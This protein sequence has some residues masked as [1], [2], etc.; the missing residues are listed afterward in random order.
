MSSKLLEHMAGVYTY[1][2]FLE[3]ATC[4]NLIAVAEVIGFE[5]ASVRVG[6]FSDHATAPMPTIR[7]NDKCIAPLPGTIGLLWEGLQELGLPQIGNEVAIGLPDTVRFYRYG[8][9]QRFKMH[10]DGPWEFEGHRSRL[11]LL[12]YLND[13][14]EGGATSFR[15]FHIKPKTGTLVLFEHSTWHEGMVVE[16]GTKYV[17]RSD[18]LYEVPK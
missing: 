1:P 14:Y 4:L 11:T 8:P 6:E 18:V 9:G 3:S 5:A 10:R 16:S 2:N 13:D 12:V 17:L 7:N 15:K